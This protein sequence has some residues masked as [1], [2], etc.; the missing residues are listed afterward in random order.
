MYRRIIE[1]DSLPYSYR[2]RTDN[3]Y[4]L[5]FAVQNKRFSFVVLLFII[6]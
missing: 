3:N 2:T 4:S 1:L 5:L 6:S